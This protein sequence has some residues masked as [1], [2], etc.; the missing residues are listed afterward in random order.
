M[1][2]MIFSLK[3]QHIIKQEKTRITVY[4][5]QHY[6]WQKNMSKLDWKTLRNILFI[7]KIFWK[8]DRAGLIHHLII[9]GRNL[10][11]T[12]SNQAEF[13]Q[14]LGDHATIPNTSHIDIICKNITHSTHPVTTT[15]HIMTATTI[16]DVLNLVDGSTKT[17][18]VRNLILIP[19]FIVE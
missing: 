5:I 8:N 3:Y 9:V 11:E 16:E 1:V 13:C 19:P 7:Q 14:R 18:K 6:P 4:T 10:C 17:Y 2:H 12:F 15:K